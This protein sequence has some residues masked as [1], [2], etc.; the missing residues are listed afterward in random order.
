M[1]DVRQR[2][3]QQK[4]D[5]LYSYTKP[6]DSIVDI[7]CGRGGD[8]HKWKKRNLNVVAVDP[9]EQYISDARVRDKGMYVDWRVGTDCPMGQFD[10]ASAMFSIHHS[11]S[12]DPVNQI[13]TILGNIKPGG[14][15]FGCIPDGDDIIRDKEFE[16]SEGSFHLV[17]H[18]QVEW[19]V[20][21]P[22]FDGSICTEPIM[23]RSMLE[24]FIGLKSEKW[25]K[26][27]PRGSISY[28]YVKFAFK[29]PY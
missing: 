25:E 6:H 16:S 29:K 14:Y 8:L 28:Y 15:F 7:G 21:G 26:M 9:N 12:G 19:S 4:F 3:N 20:P 24:Y 5:L 11:V 22:Y 23:T 18:S 10:A 2:H 1:N 17:G 27:G 13:Q